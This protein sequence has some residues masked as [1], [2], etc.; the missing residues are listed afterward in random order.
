MDVTATR[1]NESASPRL[2]YGW[3]VVAATFVVLMVGFGTAYTF[4]A[5][6]YPLRDEFDATRKDVSLVFSITGFLYFSL[7]A[8]SG[9]LADRVGPRR[10]VAFGMGLVGVGLLLASRAQELWQV[11]LTYSLGVGLGVGFAYVPAIGAVQ[12]WFLIKRGSASGFAVA[13]I[14]IGTLAMPPLAAAMIDA[15]GWRTTY[16]ILGAVCLVAGIAAALLIEHSPQRRG[17]LPD[18][19]RIAPASGHAGAPAAPYGLA[20]REALT[21]RPFALLYAACLATSLGLFIPFAHLAAYARDHGMSDTAG[22][23]LVAFIGLGSA[24]GRL[25]LGSVA[26]RFG[27]RPSLVVSFAGMAVMLLWWLVAEQLWSLA[28]FAV[29]FGVCYGGFVALIPALAS[30]YFGGKNAGAILGLLYTGPAFGALLGPY[31]AGLGYDL[32]ESYAIPILF[33]AAANLLAVACICIMAKPARWR[34]TVPSEPDSSQPRIEP[35]G[36]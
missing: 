5:F 32:R 36:V 23:W 22:A 19:E 28:L 24:V 2:F 9:P 11:Y 13:G 8:V 1:A 33:A 27:R 26:D 3:I 34:A 15:G 21:S 12:R 14:G 10:V 31:L 7:G 17:L 20:T 6:F 35:R 18:G 29:I 25:G 16:V 4:A 30:D